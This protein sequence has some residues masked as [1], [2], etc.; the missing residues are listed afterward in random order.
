[1]NLSQRARWRCETLERSSVG[2]RAKNAWRPGITVIVLHMPQASLKLQKAAFILFKYFISACLRSVV[3]WQKKSLPF[4]M[5]Q[6]LAHPFLQFNCQTT[7]LMPSEKKR[8][9]KDNWTPL[10]VWLLLCC[11]CNICCLCPARTIIIIEKINVIMKVER[12]SEE[13]KCLVGN[14]MAFNQSPGPACPFGVSSVTFY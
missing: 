5:T 1:M 4:G 8:K 6:C 2:A 14:Q 11:E 9:R 13:V 7:F 3:L 10:A 12:K